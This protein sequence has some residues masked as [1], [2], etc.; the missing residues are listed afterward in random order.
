MSVGSG[1][2]S[3][4]LPLLVSVT[5]VV[6]NSMPGISG[7]VSSKAPPPCQPRLQ[8]QWRDAAEGGVIWQALT[9]AATEQQLPLFT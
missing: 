5:K 9:N 2:V 6:T 8:C 1:G 7:E 3:D 4:V